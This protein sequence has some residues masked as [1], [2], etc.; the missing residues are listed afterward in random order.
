ML[1]LATY[2]ANA[3]CFVYADSDIASIRIIRRAFT[4]TAEILDL[5]AQATDF[6]DLQQVDVRFLVHACTQDAAARTAQ[7]LGQE[8]AGFSDEKL[9]I[10]GP[11][12]VSR[13]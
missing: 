9:W 10:A 1:D 12:T 13:L 11:P 8:A 7:F 3:R 5:R 4:R 2:K 6:D